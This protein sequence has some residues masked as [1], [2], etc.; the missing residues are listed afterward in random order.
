MKAILALL[1]IVALA[2]CSL[3]ATNATI[4]SDVSASL[5][6]IC[7]SISTAHVAIVTVEA[8]NPKIPANVVT[9]E[10]AAFDVASA[11]CANPPSDVSSIMTTVANSYAIIMKDL[12]A[13]KA[14]KAS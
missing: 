13:A 14:A 12:A 6:T 2:G 9:N 5:P 3:T 7:A 11:I 1:P 4:Q 10:Q 8:A